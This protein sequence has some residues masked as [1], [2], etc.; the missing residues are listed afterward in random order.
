MPGRSTAGASW[1]SARGPSGRGGA[2]N[3]GRTAR[4]GGRKAS[5]ISGRVAL[6]ALQARPEAGVDQGLD[7]SRVRRGRVARTPRRGG[8]V[9]REVGLEPAR[10]GRGPPGSWARST[11]DLQRHTHEEQHEQQRVDHAKDGRVGAGTQ[12]RLGG[13]RVRVSVT[14]GIISSS[15]VSE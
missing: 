8:R 7:G 13:T 5:E 4:S 12:G 11:P 3:S 6:L 9:A 2:S 14:V 15:T 1:A 10:E